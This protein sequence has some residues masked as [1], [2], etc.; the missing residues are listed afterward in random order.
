VLEVEAEGAL[1]VDDRL[2]VMEGRVGV[3]GGAGARAELVPHRGVRQVD[4][5]DVD[6]LAPPA[7]V[8]GAPPAGGGLPSHRHAASDRCGAPPAAN[9]GAPR[10]LTT[11]F[12][13]YSS[14]PR[15]IAS[16][17]AT[18]SGPRKST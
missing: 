16:S 6:D 14:S 7:Q 5:G 3:D 13:R 18:P 15:A 11:R 10:R 8:P 12:S 17:L 4:E 2:G 1:D 9:A